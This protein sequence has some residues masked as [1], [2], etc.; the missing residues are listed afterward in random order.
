MYYNRYLKYK[1][2]YL[3]LKTSF[4]QPD[5]YSKPPDTY[6]VISISSLYGTIFKYGKYVLKVMITCNDKHKEYQVTYNNRIYKKSTMTDNEFK[7]EVETLKKIQDFQKGLKRSNKLTPDFIAGEYENDLLNYDDTNLQNTSFENIKSHLAQI[8]KNHFQNIDKSLKFGL[9]I[10]EYLN[11]NP[12]IT[13]L[14]NTEMKIDNIKDIICKIMKK[15]QILH[16]NNIVHNDLHLENI[17]ISPTKDIYII[18]FGLIKCA[19]ISKIES[20]TTTLLNEFIN[21]SSPYW[22]SKHWQFLTYILSKNIQDISDN[23]Y[24]ILLILLFTNDKAIKL[25]YNKNIKFDKIELYNRAG[26]KFQEI[27]NVKTKVTF[28]LDIKCTSNAENNY[29]DY[30]EL[31]E[32]T[33]PG[34]DMEID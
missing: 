5:T 21:N 8:K 7:K 17:L 14:K 28:P 26:I 33:C 22:W 32:L 23:E 34:V 27:F 10:M 31:F 3:E 29:E 25:L 20:G 1:K 13:Y 16:I 18:D 6:D 30:K 15:L 11:S 4:N 9:I 19:T 12:L 24:V 2:K